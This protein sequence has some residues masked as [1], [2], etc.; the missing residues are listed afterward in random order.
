MSRDPSATGPSADGS[1]AVQ[2]SGESHPS[3]ESQSA[4][5]G[6]G[7]S[8]ASNDVQGIK[9]SAPVWMRLSG[10]GM[11]LAFITIVFGAVGV[12]IDRWLQLQRPIASALLGLFGFT[13]G[14]IR[15]I[16]L[17]TSISEA[18]R[19]FEAS[20]SAESKDDSGTKVRD[21]QG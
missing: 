5:G 7:I 14:M 2:S 11:E 6:P 12:A 9:A 10:A 18:Q 8:G 13:F 15:F 1:S 16:R 3:G 21:G 19:S 20:R 4:A 17:A